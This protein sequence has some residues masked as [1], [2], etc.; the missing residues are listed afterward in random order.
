MK[1][2]FNKIMAIIGL[3]LFIGITDSYGQVTPTTPDVVLFCA[4]A[5]DY[6]LG[7]SPATGPNPRWIVRHSATPLVIANIGDTSPIALTGNSIPAANLTTGYLYISY[8]DDENCESIPEEVPIY[9][10]AALTATV[11]APE[12]CEEDPATF[13]ATPV[14]ADAYTAFAYQWY[15]V[16]GGVDTPIA[17][18]TS[19]TYEPQDVL[20]GTTITY[21]VRIGYL[22]GT[23]KYCSYTTTG[24]DVTV[25]AK[26]SKPTITV[27]GATAE[28]W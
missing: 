26:P 24:T 12:Y 19:A 27:E 11:N 25:T 14:S 21:K 3:L 28:T 7:N 1:N 2:K 17:G 6:D 4:D 9:K 16:V 10:F 15:T 20:A 18:A 23:S 5:E 8:I 22:V 13:T